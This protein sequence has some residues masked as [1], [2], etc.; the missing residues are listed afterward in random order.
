MVNLFSGKKK[1]SRKEQSDVVC[2]E[3]EE[4][5]ESDDYQTVCSYKMDKDQHRRSVPAMQ[6]RRIRKPHS[7]ICYSKAPKSRR[8]PYM[9][10]EYRR[11]WNERLTFQPDKQIFSSEKP[12]VARGRRQF[13]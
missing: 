8:S 7:K 13:Y 4:E 9:E 11:D 5:S 6:Y 2:E 10:Q 1:S 12:V 3:E